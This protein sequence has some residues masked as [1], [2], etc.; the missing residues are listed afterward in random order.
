MKTKNEVLQKAWEN[1]RELLLQ[2]KTK[3]LN[4][5]VEAENGC[6]TKI[7]KFVI[8][9]DCYIHQIEVSQYQIVLN[10]IDKP[11]GEQTCISLVDNEVDEYI[12]LLVMA[13]ALLPE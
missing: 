4:V 5:F 13:K 10:T 9:E 11:T 12:K 2:D 7:K 8:D 6:D 3:P 1:F